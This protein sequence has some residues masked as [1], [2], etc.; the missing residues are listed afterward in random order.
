MTNTTTI[1]EQGTETKKEVRVIKCTSDMKINFVCFDATKD[2]MS[3][4]QF[5]ERQ[6]VF[7]FNDPIQRDSVW[8]VEKKS[9]LIVSILEE[10]SIGEIKTQTI[11]KSKKKFR[12]VLDGKQRLTTIRDYIRNRYALKDSFVQCF[13]VENEGEEVLMDVSGMYFRDLPEQYQNRIMALI[14]DIKSYED[15]DDSKKS[16]LFKRWNNGQAL[17]PS[18]IRKA[19]MSYELLHAI[20]EMK[21]LEFTQ[22]GFSASGLKNDNHSDMLLKA[23]CVLKTQNNTALDSKTID[24][25]LNQDAFKTED[26]QELKELTN[27]LN[28]SFKFMDEKHAKKSFGASKSIT[29]IFVAKQAMKDNCSHEDFAKWIH[30]VFVKDYNHIGYATTSGTT[31]LESVKRKNSIGLE[32]YTKFFA[33]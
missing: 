9:L 16:D 32:H 7:L 6:P 33:K 12:N 20:A 19:M 27:Y 31:K 15:L 2:E 18:Q 5:M 10:V 4:A 25:F 11:R 22:A 30:A 17:K 14:L 21:E 13:D 3:V 1:I 26:I 8:T 28:E 29:L 24:G 23:L